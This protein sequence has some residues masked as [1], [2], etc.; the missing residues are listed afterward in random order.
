[1]RYP[2]ARPIT[3]RPIPVL[4][5]VPSTIVAPGL[6]RPCCFRVSDDSVGGSIFHRSGRVHEIPPFRES[7]NQ[8]VRT[9]VA[10]N[11]R[12]V[13]DVFR[14]CPSISQSCDLNS[15]LEIVSHFSLF[16]SHFFCGASITPTNALGIQKILARGPSEK[17][18]ASTLQPFNAAR[19][20][21]MQSS[22]YPVFF[23]LVLSTSRLAR[24]LRISGFPSAQALSIVI[25]LKRHLSRSRVRLQS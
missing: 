14:D 11:Q 20:C 8:S 17:N 24:A 7:H 1:M 10:V 23:D 9:G 16:D 25:L 3:A 15:L 19:L 22:F 6:S 4:P 21:R 18:S 12:R 5:A 13:P 2:L